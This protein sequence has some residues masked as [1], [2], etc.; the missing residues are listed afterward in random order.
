MNSPAT[1]QNIGQLL[2]IGFDGT[3]MSSRLRSQLT[4]IQPAGVILFARNIATAEQTY[5]LLKDCQ[6]CVSTPLITCVD[7]EGGL[8]DRFRK[9]L[10]PSPSAADVFAAGERKI[11]RKHGR[12][13]GQC[14]SALGFNT[15][16][17]PV[18]DL[19]F[20]KS[21]KVLGSR[22]VSANPKET[23]RYA[24]EFL[25]GLRSAGVL[26]C[27]K[28]FP[29]LGE[30]NL[31]THRRLPQVSKSWKALW[32]DDLKPYRD[33]RRGAPMV[34]VAH[35][36][37]PS[38]TK[39]PTPASLSVKWIEGVLRKKIGYRGL[40]MSDD[41]EMGAVLRA[42]TISEAAVAHIRAGGDLALI[43][44]AEENVV[45]GYGAL[46]KEAQHNPAFG[47]RCQESIHKVLAFKKQCKE[48]KRHA[49]VP[50]QAKLETLTRELWEFGEQVR[51]E[52]ITSSERRV[53]A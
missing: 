30:A 43:C 33:L 20:K 28:H 22:A 46:L 29:G 13:I 52:A 26:G 36:A 50:S 40:V 24:R 53:R 2:V 6:S 45:G 38:V 11:F 21:D 42:G 10:A 14:C 1:L 37:Y 32:R 15:D 41:L 35:A 48:L 4:R 49:A 7:M 31:D 3:E 8:V 44:H 19:A 51:I 9:V 27:L 34:L 16:L 12:I 23:V 18:V 5:Q 25:A 17:A 47:R 39:T